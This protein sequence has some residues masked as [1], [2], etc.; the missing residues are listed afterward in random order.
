MYVAVGATIIGFLVG[1][2]CMKWKWKWKMEMRWI[3]EE[4]HV[5]WDPSIFNKAF[6]I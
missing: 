1:L 3:L 6:F 2:E 4:A 5:A